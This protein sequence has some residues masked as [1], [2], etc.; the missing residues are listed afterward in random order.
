[1]SDLI[2][3]RE[4][5]DALDKIGSLD[6]NADK[7]YARELFKA[8]PSAQSE[9]QWIPCSERLPDKYG[10]YLTTHACLLAYEVRTNVFVN[11][12][13]SYWLF[14]EGPVIAWMEMPKPYKAES[15]DKMTREEAIADIRDNIKPVVRGKSLDMAIEALEQTRWIKCSDRLPDKKGYYL[16]VRKNPKGHV[17]RARFNPEQVERGVY[18][19]PWGNGDCDI[20][21]WMP[22]P[23]YK[24][25]RDDNEMD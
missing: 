9:Q 22:L 1:M 20:L 16:V 6:T 17:T 25:T 15:E 14:G 24:E 12:D 5:I 8:L 23:E 7:I 18:N 13:P 21:A 3:R 11:R 19:S 2:S 10:H 4:A